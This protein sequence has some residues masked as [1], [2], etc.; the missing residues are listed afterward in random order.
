MTLNVLLAGLL[1]MPPT[2]PARLSA[3]GMRRVRLGRVLVGRCRAPE[4][5]AWQDAAA[6]ATPAAEAEH[7]LCQQAPLREEMH[8]REEAA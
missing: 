8:T 2:V 3:A 1:E 4:R 6:A 7:V 5:A